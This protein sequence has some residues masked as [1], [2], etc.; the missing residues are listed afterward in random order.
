MWS[1]SVVPVRGTMP[2]SRANRKTTWLTVRP[3]RCGDPGQ[4]GTG[5]RLAVGG[6]QREA[7]VDQPVGGAELPDVAVPAPGGVA[8]VLDEAGPDA[9]LLAQA[10]EL[11]EGDVA[12][13]EQAGP[14]AV[15]DAPPSP[16]TPPSR[17]AARPDRWVG[18]CST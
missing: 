4:L 13:A 12:D 8:A 5:Q 15:V 10:L 1:A 7:L 3:W 9:R 2:T 14:A 6:Q 11:F 18:P 17:P 16:A